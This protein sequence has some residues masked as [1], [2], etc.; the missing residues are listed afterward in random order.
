MDT[1]E[2]KVGIAIVDDERELAHLF[3]ILFKDRGYP[4]C[5]VAYNGQEAVDLFKKSN[6]WP[7]VIIMD[8]RMPVMTGIEAMREILA[9]DPDVK[10]IFISADEHTKEEALK[11]G[12]VAFLRKPVSLRQII[13]CVESILYT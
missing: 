8:Q 4:I 6:P 3:E 7:R 2:C 12:A 1:S 9:I 10:I 11:S 13:S 5:F